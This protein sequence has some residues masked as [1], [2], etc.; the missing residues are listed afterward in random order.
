MIVSENYPIAVLSPS[1]E[2]LS[3]AVEAVPWE[4]QA[5]ASVDEP[6]AWS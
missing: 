3:Q 6:E 1:C 5:F 4:L 2:L